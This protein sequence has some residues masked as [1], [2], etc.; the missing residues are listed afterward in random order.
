MAKMLPCPACRKKVSEEASACP[1]CGHPLAG[2]EKF[3]AR[4]KSRRR[5][6]V[7]TYLVVLGLL[8]YC[9]SRVS[10]SPEEVEP[11]MIPVPPKAERDA[12]AQ[13]RA[14][15]QAAETRS[16]LAEAHAR[17]DREATP[18]ERGRG[19]HRDHRRP[20]LTFGPAAAR[21]FGYCC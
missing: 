19:L 15:E 2:D 1:K 5:G 14:A 4:R 20:N 9:G 7:A 8:C 3:Q 11:A 6:N 12:R 21:R 10:S 13:A 17:R 16:K 18:K